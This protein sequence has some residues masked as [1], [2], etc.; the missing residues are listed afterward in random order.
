MRLLNCV[1]VI[2]AM[3]MLCSPALAEKY[4]MVMTGA[5]ETPPADPDGLATGVLTIDRVANTVTWNFTYSN[6]AAP[7]AMHIHTGA[8]GT[9]GGV[10][11]NLGVGTTGG[12]GTLSGTVATSATNLT[13]IAANPAGF[14]VNIHNTPFPGGV[15]R[16]QLTPAPAVEFPITMTGANEVPGPGDPD[17]SATGTLTVN[18]G[19]NTLAWNF[20]YSNLDA[21]TGFHIH[22]GAV[23][24]SGG[25]FVGLG[26]ATTGGPNTLV[27]S[28]ANQTNATINSLLATPESFYLNLHTTAFPGG[29]VRQQILPPPPPACPSDLDGDGTVGGADLGIL[30]SAWGTADPAADLNGDGTVGGGDL[31]L[32]LGAWGPCPI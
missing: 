10:L 24:V 16:S 26:T 17:G 31:G 29:A 19:T 1:A 4:N 6:I 28:V 3:S 20:T 11:I 7:T 27:N 30:L 2:A 14:Y 21:L 23:G 8:A 22:T 5:N 12:P 32:M 25:V 18:P 15:L 9:N 13:N